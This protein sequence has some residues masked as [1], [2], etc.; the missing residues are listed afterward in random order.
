MMKAQTGYC[1]PPSKSQFREG[2]SGNPRGRPRGTKNK[3]TILKE[4]AS[5]EHF[6][7]VRSGKQKI[8]TIDL[9]FMR[10]REL[11]LQGD[12]KALEAFTAWNTRLEDEA[13]ARWTVGLWVSEGT[14]GREDSPLQIEEVEE[15]IDLTSLP[16]RAPMV[17]D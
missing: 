8:A 1:K 14:Y 15:T 11:A 9:L 7:T 6:V 5:E 3:A 16:A 13:E 17:S 12:E 2:Q 10:L 4:I